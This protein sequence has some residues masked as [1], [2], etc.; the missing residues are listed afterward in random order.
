[1]ASRLYSAGISARAAIKTGLGIRMTR[2]SDRHWDRFHG[3]VRANG[4]KIAV[5]HFQSGPNAQ[6]F[7]S[8][9]VRKVY[10]DFLQ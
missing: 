3:D 1:M 5:G 4:G 8:P 10:I 7:C 2:A 9:I 6:K